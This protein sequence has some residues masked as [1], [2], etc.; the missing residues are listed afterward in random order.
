MFFFYNVYIRDVFVVI[1]QNNI[2]TFIYSFF[3][4]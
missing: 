2:I 4:K 3:L 1:E